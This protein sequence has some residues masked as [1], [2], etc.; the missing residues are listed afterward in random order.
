MNKSVKLTR[1]LSVTAKSS[2]KRNLF[3]ELV[4]GLKAL[5]EARQSGRKLR[6]R[7]MPR[8]AQRHT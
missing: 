1:K 2:T 5:A 4:E 6:T 3:D 8:R 7:S